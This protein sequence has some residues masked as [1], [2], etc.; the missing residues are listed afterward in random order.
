MIAER[1]V[2]VPMQDGVR[3]CADVFRPDTGEPLPALL[4]FASYN[5]DQQAPDVAGT[6]RAP[7]A[8]VQHRDDEG[9]AHTRLVRRADRPV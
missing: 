8:P 1:D 7:P 2:M 4:A 5:K 9:A 3:L 6:G